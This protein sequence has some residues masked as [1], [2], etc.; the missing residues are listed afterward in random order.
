M[1]SEVVIIEGGKK[2]DES[3]K[4]SKVVFLIVGEEGFESIGNKRRV[5]KKKIEDSPRR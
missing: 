1:K 4:I 5:G 2:F 3:N